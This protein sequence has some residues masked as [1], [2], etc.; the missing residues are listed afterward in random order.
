MKTMLYFCAGI[1]VL[2]G[3]MICTKPIARP[4]AGGVLI[5]ACLLGIVAIIQKERKP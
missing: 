1:G 4:V 5:L 3:V 2:I